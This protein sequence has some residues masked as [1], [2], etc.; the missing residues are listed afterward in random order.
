MQLRKARSNHDLVLEWA[1]YR[2]RLAGMCCFVQKQWSIF[3]AV[4]YCTHH[5]LKKIEI[6]LFVPF[7]CAVVGFY[8]SIF[9]H[10]CVGFLFLVLYPVRSSSASVC[11]RHFV[12]QQL[13]HTTLSH[14]HSLS[15]TTL[16]HTIFD[17]QLCHTQS[18]THTI[19]HTQSPTH[20]FVTHNLRHRQSLTHNFV[21]HN[22][23]HTH[24][25]SHTTTFT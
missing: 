8:M 5:P 3:G 16:L 2:K 12:T 22:L 21:T 6:N 17:T 14:T 19:F 23:G 18:L 25:L 10:L 20:N 24:N 4:A 1:S 9:P 13:S 11:L 7:F 15:H